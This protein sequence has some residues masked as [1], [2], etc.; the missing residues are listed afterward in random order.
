MIFLD[1]ENPYI[2]FNFFIIRI[3]AMAKI[4]SICHD[5]QELFWHLLVG[6]QGV[7]QNKNTLPHA[8]YT[9]DPQHFYR[10]WT[11][12]KITSEGGGAD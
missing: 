9:S 10:F 4:R 11:P 1:L 7:T 5:Y 6:F 2:L 3:F 12:Y 8:Q